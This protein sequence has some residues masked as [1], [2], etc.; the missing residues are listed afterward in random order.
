[1]KSEGLSFEEGREYFLKLPEAARDNIV[2]DETSHIDDYDGTTRWKWTVES[3][4]ESLSSLFEPYGRRGLKKVAKPADMLKIM[5][6]LVKLVRDNDITRFPLGLTMRDVSVDCKSWAV[7][8]RPSDMAQ[9]QAKWID[10]TAL[11]DNILHKVHSE[12]CQTRAGKKIAGEFLELTSAFFMDAYHRPTQPKKKKKKKK[13]KRKVIEIDDEIDV[14]PSKKV[15][16]DDLFDAVEIIQ[17]LIKSDQNVPFLTQLCTVLGLSLDKELEVDF[18][19]LGE[20]QQ[21]AVVDLAREYKKKLCYQLGRQLEQI[22]KCVT[23]NDADS[24]MQS[25]TNLLGE[26]DTDGSFSL[27]IHTNNETVAKITEL[28]GAYTLLAHRCL[29]ERLVEIERREAA[30][31]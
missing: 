30:L 10:A 13:R 22:S 1:M 6:N 28:I 29:D 20:K 31:K 12:V 26:R 18:G 25:L 3:G 24:L 15:V 5:K 14:R 4:T 2:F 8:L 11:V 17:V 27:G 7:T 9:G 23:D 16:R 21:G 19:E